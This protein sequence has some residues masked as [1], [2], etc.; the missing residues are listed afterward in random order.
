MPSV[1]TTINIIYKIF[2]Y[3]GYRGSHNKKSYI[4]LIIIKIKEKE[5]K[6]KK[7]KREKTDL[8][9]KNTRF[10]GCFRSDRSVKYFTLTNCVK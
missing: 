10:Y 8:Q 3:Y 7:K 4:L 5:S 1:N 6:P 9:I 2:Y